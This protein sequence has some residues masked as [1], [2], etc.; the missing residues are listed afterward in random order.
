MGSKANNLG[1]TAQAGKSLSTTLKIP[2]RRLCELV[3]SAINPYRAGDFLGES[4]SVLR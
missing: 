1:P 4:F 3:S 2:E